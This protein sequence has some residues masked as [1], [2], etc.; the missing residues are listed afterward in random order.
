MVGFDVGV[1]ESADAGC[2][3]QAAQLVQA[4]AVF[5]QRVPV[6]GLAAENVARSAI[7]EA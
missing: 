3:E 6:A 2:Q 1:E 4:V 5:V 7:A